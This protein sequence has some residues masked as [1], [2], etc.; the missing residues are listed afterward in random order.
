MV[1]PAPGEAGTCPKQG[2]KVGGEGPRAGILWDHDCPGQQF[3]KCVLHETVAKLHEAG[4]SSST[5]TKTT[6]HNGL[7]AE[8]A[9]RKQLSSIEPGIKEVCKNVRQCHVTL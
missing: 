9:T 2:T 1:T 6:Y 7:D 8:A 4:F 3:P 5:A